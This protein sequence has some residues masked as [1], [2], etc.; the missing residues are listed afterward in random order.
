MHHETV[1]TGDQ[2]RFIGPYPPFDR[3]CNVC[4]VPWHTCIF[5]PA[6]FLSNCGRRLPISSPRQQTTDCLL[7]ACQWWL[8]VNV[9][10]WSHCNSG[11]SFMCAR[12]IWMTTP[13]LL[14]YLSSWVKHI[15]KVSG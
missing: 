4:R 11:P 15:T 9:E 14:A 8:I 6:G 7:L 1:L 10:R 2:K 5:S 3:Y 12:S 13:P